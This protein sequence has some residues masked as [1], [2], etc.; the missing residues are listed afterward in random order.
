M[1]GIL[2][3]SGRNWKTARGVK[4]G[5]GIQFDVYG[6]IRVDGSIWCVRYIDNIIFVCCRGDDG[7][8]RRNNS[9][10]WS[11]GIDTLPPSIQMA[12]GRSNR[13]GLM[14]TEESGCESRYCCEVALAKCA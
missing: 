1:I 13:I 4:V 6:R 8:R 12:E 3:A 7:R 10:R 11:C 5:S 2:G 9:R 14:L